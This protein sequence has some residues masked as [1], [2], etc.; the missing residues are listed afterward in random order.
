MDCIFRLK[1]E[2]RVIMYRDAKHVF[3]SVYIKHQ[4]R[5]SLANDI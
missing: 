3:D 1:V 4:H 2:K 5:E